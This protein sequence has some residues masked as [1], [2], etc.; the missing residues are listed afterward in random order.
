MAAQSAL[1]PAPRG[2]GSALHL[3]V[4]LRPGSR[5]PVMQSKR[6]RAILF[7]NAL[8]EVETIAV[9]AIASPTKRKSLPRIDLAALDDVL[10]HPGCAAAPGFFRRVPAMLGR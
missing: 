7:M 3:S 10:E 5:M 6:R 9:P 4:F 1:P 2:D 8:V